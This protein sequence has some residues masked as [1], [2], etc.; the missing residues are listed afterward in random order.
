MLA[1]KAPLLRLIVKGGVKKK[2]P[3]V[4]VSNHIEKVR[5]EWEVFVNF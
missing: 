4:F 2:F 1:S 3:K 5:E